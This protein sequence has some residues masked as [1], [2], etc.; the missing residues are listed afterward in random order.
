MGREHP[1]DP[2]R[3]PARTVRIWNW[4]EQTELLVLQGHTGMPPVPWPLGGNALVLTADHC[5]LVKGGTDCS[6]REQSLRRAFA[7]GGNRVE[8][9][10]PSVSQF[11]F[12]AGSLPVNNSNPQ[13][14]SVSIVGPPGEG[15]GVSDFRSHLPLRL[16]V[17]V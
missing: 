4:A 11:F 7:P 13:S 2:N 9:A 5:R 15:G 12:L 1:G 14:D 16:S 10:S 8:F 6:N 3:S 17:C